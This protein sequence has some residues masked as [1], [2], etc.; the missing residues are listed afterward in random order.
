MEFNFSLRINDFNLK[1]YFKFIKSHNRELFLKGKTIINHNRPK[2]PT[3]KIEIYSNGSSNTNK[4]ISI[5]YETISHELSHVFEFNFDG[6]E[7]YSFSG[8]DLKSILT[9]FVNEKELRAHCMELQTISKN[10]SLHEA[11]DDIINRYL[12]NI[13]KHLSVFLL[14]YHASYV[15]SNKILKNR[16]Y[17]NLLAK[18]T[19]P[20]L[21][22]PFPIMKEL[23][24]N[25][26]KEL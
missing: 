6:D 8:N 25:F 24:K 15:K 1:F 23:M 16:Y 13:P 4:I 2:T 19:N 26:I 3:I 12:P 9:Y 22:E 10:K 11:W 7:P 21:I 20:N 5:F 17:D 18:M 14:Y